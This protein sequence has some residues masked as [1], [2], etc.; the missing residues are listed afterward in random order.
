MVSAAASTTT[1]F[2]LP[3]KILF[4]KDGISL[5]ATALPTSDEGGNEGNVA[6]AGNDDGPDDDQHEGIILTL[7][8]RRCHEKNVINPTMISLLIQALDTIDSNPMLANTNNKSMIITGLSLDENDNEPSLSKFFSNG[9]DL[10]WM[11]RA[12]DNDNSGKDGKESFRSM[13]LGARKEPKSNPTSTL[14]ESFNSLVLARILTL[15]F[16]TVAAING[17]CIGGYGF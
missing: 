13:E 11:L 12:N 7:T 10:E 15:P 9:L 17:H 5:F 4:N 6:A 14:I 16:R 1:S 8:L 2:S 3:T